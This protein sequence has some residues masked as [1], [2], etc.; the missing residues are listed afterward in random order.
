M[1]ARIL[2]VPGLH[3]SGPN[4]WQTLWERQYPTAH[5][6]TQRDWDDPRLD[7]WADRL[8]HAILK[9]PEPVVIVAHSFGCLVTAHAASRRKLPIRGA[10]LVAPASPSRFNVINAMPR[11]RLPFSTMLVA[12]W[13]DPWLTFPKACFWAFTWGSRLID[14]GAAGHINAEAGFGR[15][16][17]GEQLLQQLL[18]ENTSPAKA[19]FGS[20]AEESYLKSFTISY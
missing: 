17:L 2:I 1:S 4:H 5:R 18:T 6:V 19:D 11:R 15:W 13:N 3:N 20:A 7:E 9:S 14:L 12:S 10:L 8:E 16:P